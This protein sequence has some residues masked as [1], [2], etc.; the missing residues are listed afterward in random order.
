MQPAHEGSVVED[1]LADPG[2]VIASV[3]GGGASGDMYGYMVVLCALRGV[4]EEVS[5]HGMRVGDAGVVGDVYA[6]EPRFAS[7]PPGYHVVRGEEGTLAKLPP[8]YVYQAFRF[9]HVVERAESLILV[10]GRGCALKVEA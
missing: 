5:A 1:L 4:G 6:V 3:L 2:G 8:C 10:S 7:P 9:G